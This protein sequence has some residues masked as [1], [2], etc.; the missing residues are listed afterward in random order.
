MKFLLGIYLRPEGRNQVKLSEFL[1]DLRRLSKDCNFK[2]VS[3]EHYREELVRDS[4]INGLLSPLIHQ[5]LL[6][7]SQLD[8]KSAFDQA[9]ALD[10]AQKNAEAYT[11][12]QMPTTASVSDS[13]NGHLNENLAPISQSTEPVTASF[14]SSNKCYFCGD[15]LHNRKNCPARNPV[16]DSCGKRGH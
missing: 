6:G 8:L 16:C 12:P 3:A 14:T 10:L 9:N 7:N 4:F 2:N 5:R 15:T 1:Q 11:M 13:L